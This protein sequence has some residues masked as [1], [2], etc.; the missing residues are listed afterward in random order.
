MNYSDY[1]CLDVAR[2]GEVLRVAIH[3]PNS[4]YNLVD[5]DLHRDL[6]R[7]FRELKQ[8]SSARSVLLE[9]RGDAF[10]AGGNFHW[11][12]TM[13]TPQRL[14]EVSRDGKQL[15]W[16]MLDVQVPIIASVHG[17]AM[18]LGA[19]IA[20]FC[21]VIFMAESALIADP[22]VR[23]GIVAGDGGTVA[24]PLAVGPAR[25]KEY[26]LTGDPLTA[27][28]A[29]RIGLINHA[30]PDDQLDERALA[31]AR[32][33]AAGAPLAIQYTKLAV[34]NLLKQALGV[35]FDVSTAHELLTFLSDDH[36]EAVDAFLSK[37]PPTFTGK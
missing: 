8:E 19:S 20:L 22:H 31:F 3:H 2:D 24:W 36:V 37:R 6:A 11:F 33:I 15:I 26:L 27:V 7:L 18:G 21:D 14:A 30:V 1:T 16:D 25:A 9:A 12:K 32:R 17:N 23:A 13:R 10:S 4:K 5:D 28:E 29:E 34:N 35:S